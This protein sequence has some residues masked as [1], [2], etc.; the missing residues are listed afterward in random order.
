M[1]PLLPFFLVYLGGILAALPAAV[2]FWLPYFLPLPVIVSGIF[3]FGLKK[4]P[5][6]GPSEK[7]WTWRWKR[8]PPW[9]WIVLGLLLPL[10]YI[11]LDW[12]ERFRPSHHIFNHLQE[13]RAAVVEGR[14]YE[15]PRRSSGQVRY[16]VR[17]T[18]IRY[19]GEE[20][21]VTGR[22]RITR[23]DPPDSM[24]TFRAGDILRFVNVRLKRPRN[25][26]NPGRFDYRRYMEARGIAVIG[27]L[28]RKTSIQ[29]LGTFRLPVMTALRI[30]LR[31]RLL[32]TLNHLFPG[33]E[34]ALLQGML[35]GDK[36]ALSREIRETY[37][38]TGIAHLLAVS[39]LHI[40]FVAAA[41]YMLVWPMMFYGL[42]RIRPEW[43]QSGTSRKVAVFLCFFPVIFYM[44][45]VGAK[46]SVVRSGIMVLAV[47]AA[48]LVNRE[49]HLFN[50][51]LAAAFLILA[52]NPKA[53]QDVGFQLSFGALA[54]ILFVMHHLNQLWRDPVDRLGEPSWAQKIIRGDYS[55]EAGNSIWQGIHQRLQRV[56]AGCGFISLAV[57]FGTLP[58]LIFHFNRVS[59][60]GV[61][62]NLILVPCASV[63][64]PLALFLICLGAAA[65]VLAGILAVPVYYLLKGFILLPG[66][67]SSW[68]FASLYVPTPPR[69]WFFLYYALLFGGIFAWG[70]SRKDS[71]DS[72][73]RNVF[74]ERGL[75]GVLVLSAVWVIVWFIWPRFPELK[76]GTLKVSILDVGQGESI[77]IEFPDRK[78]MILD[79]GG[80]F[81]NVLDVGKLVVAPFLWNQGLRHID[82]L[83]VTHSDN[84]H[85][86]GLES[87][88]DLFSVGYYLDGFPGTKDGRIARL[89]GKL[90]K[91]GAIWVPLKVGKVFRI[92]NAA[93]VPLSPEPRMLET[94]GVA[95][96]NRVGNDLSLVLRLEYKRFSMLLT[97]DIG[98]K[99]ESYL[100]QKSAPLRS[101]ILK[102]PH[103]GSRFSNT[104]GFIKAVGPSEV[105]FSAGYL[106]RMRLPAPEVVRRYE[107]AGVHV[108]RTDLDGAIRITTDGFQQ[109]IESYGIR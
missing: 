99:T 8:P 85:I 19:G 20:I 106:N 26:R 69:P 45:L 83:A 30:A 1:A 80:F 96:H 81:K 43:S 87:L 74:N 79:G 57:L 61:F 70:W 53:V 29:K 10:G 27:S 107:K 78:T 84:D 88:A 41:A 42:Y 58:I 47:L 102:G 104:P 5:S 55:Q 86:S 82:Y 12:N 59:L 75:Q 56:F 51:L 40:G 62:L 67:V 54:A 22:A 4:I 89:K 11:S 7:Y 18:R 101:R 105:I 14:L 2:H 100:V 64:I 17:L 76:S 77:F 24:D 15:P 92:G 48:I 72:A 34:G 93:L 95:A 31:H 6:T 108:W 38:A 21:A 91:K 66:I 9:Q 50:A 68:S 109:R 49:R 52:W 13:G 35:F 36:T 16:F 103:H 32:S 28:G 44:F 63:L 98:R 23:Y 97:G 73:P 25:F 37:I 90:L 71:R 94:R 39:G 33:E 65:P 3:V 60:V 46:V